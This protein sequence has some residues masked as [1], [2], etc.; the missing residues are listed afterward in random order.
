MDERNVGC[1]AIE[2]PDRA[3]GLAIAAWLLYPTRTAPR[4]ETFGPWEIACAL[5]APVD[6]AGATSLVAFSHGNGASPWVHRDLIV[7]LV[8]HGFAVAVLEHPGNNRR[9]NSLGGPDGVMKL[10]NLVRRPHHLR[11]VIDAAFA[12]AALGPHLGPAV[13]VIGT[14][15]GGYTAAAIAGGRALTFPDDVG[16]RHAPDAATLARLVPVATERDPRV[17]AAV[18]LVPALPFFAAPGALAAVDAHL[19]VRSGALDP[20]CP[21]AQVAHALREVPA[22][23]VDHVT[24][25]GAAHFSFLSPFPA[26]LA[27]LPAA[28]DPPGF[29]RAAYQPVLARD[30][31]AFL[32]ATCPP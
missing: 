11:L 5:H 30:V 17:R 13:G 15:I 7:H 12:D 21:P 26:A 3:R 16:A 10:E 1:R 22:A 19:L 24:V 28:S 2:V 32:R 27:Q 9:D 8:R 18:L 25:P 23:A 4:S 20:I 6:P 14:S 31:T 29:D